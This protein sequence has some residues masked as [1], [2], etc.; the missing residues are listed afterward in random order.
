VAAIS[1]QPPSLL[2]TARLS[3]KL[4]SSLMLRPTVSRPVCLGIKH[5]SGAYNQIYSTVRQ[6]LVCWCG[7]LWREGGSVVYNFCWPSAAQSFSGTSPVRLATIFYCHIFETS[8]FVAFYDSQGCGGGIRPRLHTG[9]TA[10]W[11]ARRIAHWLA[12]WFAPWLAC[13]IARWFACSLSVAYWL[14]CNLVLCL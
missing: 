8:L 2:F 12:R 3:T 10:R 7:A 1:R 5:P 4:E 14:S 9:L 13:W 11:L 6:F